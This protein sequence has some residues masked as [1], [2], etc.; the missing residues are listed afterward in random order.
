MNILI[1]GCNGQL[2]N[3]LQRL[4]AS[5]VSHTFYNTDIQPSADGVANYSQL[6]ITDEDA[7][8]DFVRCHA[9]DGIINCAAYTAVDKAES[10]MEL[11]RRLNSTA[12]HILAC[13][14][15]RQGAWLIQISTDY[16]FNGEH[17]VPYT[18]DEQTCPNS[19]YG[20]TKL[21]GERKAC[22]TCRH[23]MIIRTAWLYSEYGKN[24]VKTMMKLG[25]TKDK[26]GVIFDQIG[27]PTYATDL[28][29]AIMAAVGK[30]VPAGI[31]HFS[32]E[33]AISWYDFTKAIHRISGITS[34]E[35]SPIHTDEYPTPAARPHY[36]VLDKTKIKTA[37]GIC[38]PYWED[39]LTA[40]IKNILASEGQE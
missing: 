6:D 25:R 13:A 24:F 10:D 27:T 18:E 15:E 21:E 5:N 14:A 23:T 26:L 40:C 11:C 16:V 30:G 37:L 32:N 29:R 8:N 3:S 28:A 17:H 36:S 4:Q 39:S 20:T 33:G 31:Y 34:C 19:M 12:P 1:T 9:I 38:I 22:E 2:G 35:V 7:V